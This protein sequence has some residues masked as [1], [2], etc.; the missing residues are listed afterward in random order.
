MPACE[1][2]SL[3]PTPTITSRTIFY[4]PLRLQPKAFAWR[5]IEI[6]G[7]GNA[8]VQL[9]SVSPQLDGVVG[10]GFAPFDGNDCVPTES[11]ET[12]SGAAPQ[13]SVAVTPGTYCVRVW[14]LG[15]FTADWTF[16]ITIVVPI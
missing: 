10:L 3:P 14:E 6:N 8:T 4:G 9:S 15:N 2:A 16:T 13:I 7:R 11:V 12:G 1:G 5:T